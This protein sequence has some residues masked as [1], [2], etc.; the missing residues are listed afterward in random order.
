MELRQASLRP[1]LNGA[2]PCLPWGPGPVIH[3]LIHPSLSPLI[4]LLEV[5]GASSQHQTHYRRTGDRY[6][7]IPVMETTLHGSLVSHGDISNCPQVS[8]DT[9]ADVVLVSSGSELIYSAQVSL[10]KGCFFSQ[11]SL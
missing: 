5:M 6:S 1:D 3:S 11:S 10:K 7:P 8:G 2:A 4:L 9:S